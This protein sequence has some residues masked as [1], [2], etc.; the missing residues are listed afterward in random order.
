MNIPLAERMR[1][2]HLGEYYGQKHLLGAQGSLT[3]MIE[4]SQS[5]RENCLKRQVCKEEI[6]DILIDYLQNICFGE[7]II[8][9]ILD[10]YEKISQK[11]SNYF[12][13]SF[14]QYLSN[15]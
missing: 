2:K 8:S 4:K 15:V 14:W 6:V 7:H 3:Q 12:L 10:H 11:I 1:P 13:F 5:K 9:Q